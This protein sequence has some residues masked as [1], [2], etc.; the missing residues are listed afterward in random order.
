M[1]N[2]KALIAVVCLVFASLAGAQTLREGRDYTLLASPQPTEPGKI[3][4]IEFFSYMC[5]HCAHFEPVLA[6]WVKA[7]PK[8]VAF[9]RVPVVYRPQWEAPARLYYA[10]ET[11]NELDRLHGAVFNAIH[12]DGSNLTTDEAVADWAAK[13]GLD[14]KKFTDVYGSFTV[15]SKVLRAKQTTAAYR[16][17]SVPALVIA[18]KYRTPTE[19]FTGS[20]EDLLKIANALI[21]KARAEQKR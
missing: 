2:L 12:V 4:V 10:L 20:H 18:G 19:N 11:L 8:D 7:L 6:P 21:A 16:I 3:E 9:R 13:K 1:R 5:P 17:D 14:R 15:Q